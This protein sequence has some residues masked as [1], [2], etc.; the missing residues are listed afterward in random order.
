MNAA[1]LAVRREEGRRQRGRQGNK[2]QTQ[3]WSGRDGGECLG[4]RGCIRNEQQGQPVWMEMSVPNGSGS[5][6]CCT[7]T[8]LSVGGNKM[9]KAVEEQGTGREVDRCSVQVHWRG[10][11]NLTWWTSY[12]ELHPL[13]TPTTFLSAHKPRDRAAFKVIYT[14]K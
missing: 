5:I 14:P 3:R 10:V 6:L 7:S 12:W 2:R 11:F 4:C 8:V 9:E 13:C 1:V